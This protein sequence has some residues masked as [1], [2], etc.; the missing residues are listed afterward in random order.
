MAKPFF[1]VI[2]ATYNYGHLISRAIDSVLNQTFKDFEVII[3][4]DG[5]TDGTE[6]ILVPYEAHIRYF[7]TEN[8]GQSSACNFGAKIA[9]GEFIYILDADDYLYADALENFKEE[10]VK[11]GN[12]AKRTI[13]F[14][15][16]TSVAY[17]GEK[18]TRSAKEAGKN[19]KE[20]LRRLISGEM[21]GLQHGCFV[22]PTEA[23]SRVQYAEGVRN[24]TDIVFLGRAICFYELKAIR[25][26]VLYSCEHPERSRKQAERIIKLGMA[27][28]EALFDSKYVPENLMYLKAVYQGYRH[29]TL[30]RLAYLNLDF[31]ASRTLYVKALRH[32]P[33]CMLEASSLKKFFLASVKSIFSSA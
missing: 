8:A 5:S 32:N 23:F 12:D 31:K 33:Y 30:A 13:I 20:N 28:V 6:K 29:K 15:G 19:A 24:A 17:T 1:S 14:G 2:I 3:V 9:L 18:K 26:I 25:A 27:S 22:V 21:R 10:I 7:R 4:D 11:L 16:Y